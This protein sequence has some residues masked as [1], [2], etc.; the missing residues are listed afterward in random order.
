MTFVELTY[1]NLILL[2]IFLSMCCWVC[3]FDFFLHH[4]IDAYHRIHKLNVSCS[5]LIFAMFTHSREQSS[6]LIVH[7][8]LI[9]YANEIICL[10]FVCVE[11]EVKWIDK[12]K[13]IQHLFMPFIFNMLE[14]SGKFS[15]F[16]EMLMF[17]I[18]C[19]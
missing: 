7:I 13:E 11:W 9:P 5:L 17:W 8:N 3:S 2:I 16:S 18:A 4:N 10:I 6:T 19:K 14:R 1:S 15:F 12:N